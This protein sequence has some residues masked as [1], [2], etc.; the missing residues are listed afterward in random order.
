MKL[1]VALLFLT[2]MLCSALLPMAATAQDAPYYV[3]QD[4][5]PVRPGTYQSAAKD[6]GFTE[7]GD[8]LDCRQTIH[9]FL[10]ASDPSLRLT[11]GLPPD[12]TVPRATAWLQKLAAELG[13]TAPS[14]ALNSQK[15]ALFLR[16]DFDGDWSGRQPRRLA[17]DLTVM[18]RRLAQLSDK[19]ILLGLN[20]TSGDIL[21]VD[22][23]PAAKGHAT[24][25]QVLFYRLTP[26]MG[27]L[28]LS[29]GLPPRVFAALIAALAAWLLFPPIVLFAARE[30]LRRDK[31]VVPREKLQTYRRWQRAVTLSTLLGLPVTFFLF[32]PQRFFGLGIIGPGILPAMV[33]L[34]MSLTSLSARMLG[35]PLERE[36][37]PQR[38]DIAWWRLL[39]PDLIGMAIMVLFMTGVVALPV[40]MRSGQLNLSG[41][42]VMWLFAGTGVVI[43]SIIGLAVYLPSERRWRLRRTALPKE[44]ALASEAVH[45]AVRDLAERLDAPV[46][47]VLVR[48]RR[49]IW[50]IQVAVE[51]R[52]EVAVLSEELADDLDP[53]QV[54]ALVVSQSLQE[55]R[56]KRDRLL[57]ALLSFSPLVILASSLGIVA[58]AGAGGGGTAM[59]LLFAPIV[60]TTFGALAVSRAQAKRSEEADFRVAESLSSPRQLLNALLHIE[61]LTA[62]ATGIERKGDQS[63]FAQRRL[64]LARKLGLD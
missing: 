43:A 61:E 48:L 58:S 53:E 47:R 52:G 40:M 57:R 60:L 49:P 54:A 19:P 7:W 8:A 5:R 37:W 22:P 12:I 15:D 63:P 34:P 29:T 30:H 28:N 14:L 18:E 46:R 42:G 4:S 6:A 26:G 59:L 17:F 9:V 39:A 33:L 25:S 21:S 64:K 44:E 13:M 27:S 51:A 62:L 31:R 45:E 56:E 10:R 41:R 50:N 36:A 38:R 35:L 55:P 23:P 3:A 2:V 24:M 11:I 16:A 1:S 32:G 20:V